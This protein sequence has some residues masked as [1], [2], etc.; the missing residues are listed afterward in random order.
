MPQRAGEGF[1]IPGQ[2]RVDQQQAG[3]VRH[4]AVV[5]EVD[6]PCPA[7]PAEPGVEHQQA[8]H[9]D[10]EDRCGVTEQGDHPCHMV[11]KAALVTGRDHA[12]WQ[13]DDDAEEDCQGGQLDGRREHPLDVVQHRVAGQQGVAEITVEQVVEVQPELHPDRLV[14]AHRPVHLV[15]GGAVGVRPDHGQH[16]VQRHHPTNEEGQRQQTEQGHQ[17]RA[18]PSGSAR[19]ARA[20]HRGSRN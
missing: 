1:P 17:D 14:Q 15:V 6:A 7:G 4:H 10:P 5:G 20:Q 3:D 8:H 18:G 9:A 13:A 19:H 16:R 11:A 2:G 12:Q